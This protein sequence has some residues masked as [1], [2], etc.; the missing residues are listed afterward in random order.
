MS[1]SNPN[2]LIYHVDFNSS[3]IKGSKRPLNKFLK[4]ILQPPY[5]TFH[6]ALVHISSLSITWSHD[7]YPNELKW[8]TSNYDIEFDR[9]MY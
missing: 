9:K 4:S 2:S 8:C 6:K 1:N 5:F 3:K 7:L